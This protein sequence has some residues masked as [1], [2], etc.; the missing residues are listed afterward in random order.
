MDLKILFHHKL[1]IQQ[2]F[3]WNEKKLVENDRAN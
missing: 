1:Q 2:A 3:L